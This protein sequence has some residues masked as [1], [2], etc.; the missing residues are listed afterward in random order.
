MKKKILSFIMLFA[1]TFCFASGCKND[2]DDQEVLVEDGKEVVAEI[3]G[4]KYTADQIY[5]SLVDTSSNASYL[6]EQLEDLLINTVVPVTESMKNR[7]NNEIEKWKKDLKE[8][9]TINGTAYKDELKTALEN[10]GVSSEEELYE[11][12]IFELQEEIITNQYWKAK[13][14]SYYA[15]YLNN[16]YVYHVS[17]IL[18]SVSDYGNKDAFAAE[19]TDTVAKKLYDITRQLLDGVPFYQVAE[20]YSDDSDSKNNGGDLG[21][22]TLNDVSIP[23]EVKYALAGYS[24][25]F[26]GA[27]LE[28]PAYMDN[29]YKNGVEAIAEKYI[30]VLG[31]KYDDTTSHITATDSILSGSVRVRARN[32]LFNNLFNSK[33]FRFLQSDEVGTNTKVIDNLMLS[34]ND[35][36]IYQAATENKNIVLNEAGI[37]ILVVRSSKGVHFLSITKSAFAGE[38]ELLKYYSKEIDDTDGYLT[39]VEKGVTSSERDA[40]IA[41]LDLFAKEY[42]TRKIND[43]SDNFG[44]NEDFIN[45]DMFMYYLN[46]EHK[47]VK[48]EI[49]NENIKDIVLSYIAAQ[50]D[51]IDM[52]IENVF[53]L[54]YDKLANVEENYSNTINVN[55]EIPIL[56]CLDNKGCTYTYKNGF[57]VTGGGN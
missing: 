51:Y 25:Y 35:S 22:I 31:E 54:G 47:G 32:I 10:E 33:T 29:V 57:T 8:N 43:N 49:K 36:P 40:R 50:K 34:V 48:F 52:R 41:E 39:Y 14:D 5:E 7:I 4:V 21:L 20:V 3:N 19:I 2:N 56:K 24:K 16:N 15:G 46:G 38:E 37:P 28:T 1:V 53:N 23:D 9:A 13:E 55:R 17:Q 11:K 27:D 18:V 42:A 44:G 26:E 6:Y 12:K 30:K 45:Y